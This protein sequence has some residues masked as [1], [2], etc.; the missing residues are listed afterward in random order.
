MRS[1]TAGAPLRVR[2]RIP[3][4]LCALLVAAWSVAA[5]AVRAAP[6]AALMFEDAPALSPHELQAAYQG[7]LGD[8]LDDALAEQVADALVDH[9][10]AR[11][12]LA[13]APRPVRRHDPAG[14]LVMEL[15]EPRVT[16]VQVNGREHVDDDG[17]WALVRELRATRP[18]SRAAFDAWLRRANG[19]G[20]AVRG[21]LI[22][23]SAEPHEY[24]AS[25]QVDQ[26]RWS[27]LVHV[28]NRGPAQL[29]HEIAQLS[30]N[31]R[32]PREA[33]GQVRVDVAAA[34]DHERLRYAGA[35]GSHRLAARG[36]RLR[37]KYARSE[38][39]LPV[40]DTS[41]SVDYDRERAEV[42]VVVPLT[43]RTRERRDLAIGL[44]SYDLDQFL[45][46]G[47][48]L[49][50]DRIRAV[51]LGY[52][53]I[54]ATGSGAR[55]SVEALISRGIDGLG[56]SLW[57]EGAEGDFST[58]TAEYGYRRRLGDAW[59]WH[60]DV[61]VQVSGD[62]L[63]A[64]ERFFIGGR[65]LGGAFDPAT[66]SGD[67]GLG[68]RV[69]L[70]RSLPLPALA[71]PLTAFVYYDHGWVWSN[72]DTRPADDAGSTGAGLRGRV[73]DL[74]WSVE[75]GVPVRSPETPSLLEDDT[76]VFFALSQRF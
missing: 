22:R 10:Q 69:G 50:R 47:R 68:V 24:V 27:G 9:Y 19:F 65:N 46:D 8:T 13:P 26:R 74:D 39:T 30:V 16:R 4:L 59:Q 14:V 43:R 33:L 71:R 54:V 55:H 1:E 38:S 45:D 18:L 21:S 75:V 60:S 57:P 25:L 44:R 40:V 73:G 58:V 28:D 31:Y 49:R 34:V 42:G 53:A 15:R 20:F 36:E 63:P 32:F 6:F 3:P 35:S 64:S 61:T 66:L 76:R 52:D 17:F 7:A 48:R 12:Y 5:P 62:R 72:D 67:Q 70:E 37:W 29:G 56:A 23:D 51:Q 2:Q 41:R 11:G